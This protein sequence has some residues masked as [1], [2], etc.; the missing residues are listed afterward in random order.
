VDGKMQQVPLKD[1]AK[2]TK[3]EQ[4][5]GQKFADYS[6]R[7]LMAAG[8]KPGK[9]VTPQMIDAIKEVRTNA[10]KSVR[11]SM[12]REERFGTTTPTTAPSTPPARPSPAPSTPVLSTPPRPASNVDDAAERAKARLIE[13]RKN[14]RYGGSKP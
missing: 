10:I 2:I 8:W 5:I 13:A 3:F 12:G 11:A 7:K 4:Q 9:P 1:P 6:A 14:L